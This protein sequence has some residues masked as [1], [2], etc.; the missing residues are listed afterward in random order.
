MLSAGPSLS[1]LLITALLGDADFAWADGLR[2]AHYPAARNEVPAHI[3][4]VH[5]LP[6]AREGEIRRLLAELARSA[7]PRGRLSKVMRFQRGVAL[8]IDSPELEDVRDTIAD[9]FVRDLIPVDQAADRLHITI[10]DKVSTEEA[11]AL[12]TAMSAEFCARPVAI[13]GLGLWSYRDGPWEK[14]ARY[15]FRGTKG[16]RGA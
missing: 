12:H 8:A 10:Q 14:V 1:P 9:H 4:L 15:V 6:P 2:R 13:A 7:P 11:K 5:H 3:M 16:T